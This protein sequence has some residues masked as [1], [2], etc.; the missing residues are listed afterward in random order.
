MRHSAFHQI[1]ILSPLEY[2]AL[3]VTIRWASQ[4]GVHC[5]TKSYKGRKIQWWLIL[6]VLLKTKKKKTKNKQT[7]KQKTNKQTNN[8][9]KQTNKQTKPKPKTKN[10][11]K[12]YPYPGFFL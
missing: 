5:N 11:K 8:L 12:S 9:K 4:L 6:R 3:D 10:K 2:I 1:A 7:N